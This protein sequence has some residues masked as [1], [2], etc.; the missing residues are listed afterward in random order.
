MENL[1]VTDAI[2]FCAPVRGGRNA[3]T[4]NPTEKWMSVMAQ[5]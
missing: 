1:A 5:K 3:N 4:K 2:G